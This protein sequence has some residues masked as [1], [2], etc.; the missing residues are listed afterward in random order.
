MTRKNEM[1][2]EITKRMAEL[3]AVLTIEEDVEETLIE[4]TVDTKETLNTEMI[5]VKVYDGGAADMLLMKNGHMGEIESDVTPDNVERAVNFR[6]GEY[7]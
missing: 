2:N 3:G 5:L 6:T 1:V 4:I 7:L